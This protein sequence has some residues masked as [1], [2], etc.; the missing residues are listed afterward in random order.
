MTES[1]APF[2]AADGRIAHAVGAHLLLVD[3]QTRLMAAMPRGDAERV[4]RNV[5]RLIAAADAL[6]VPVTASLQY[7]QGLGPLRPAIA[8]ALER[9]ATTATTHVAGTTPTA[10]APSAARVV[11]DLHKTAFSCCAA[12][13]LAQRLGLAAPAA[14]VG[15]RNRGNDD[16]DAASRGPGARPAPPPAPD[17]ITEATG[18][19]VVCGV[20]AHI[21]VLQT[22]LALLASGQGRRRV[23]VVSDAVTSRDPEHRLDALAR[24]R[25][26]GVIVANHESILFEW[27]RD[28]A[29]PAFKRISALLR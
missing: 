20:E 22:A 1:R 24:L 25:A 29:H 6:G 15:E 10:E 23:F 12:P 7:P 16:T 26:E 17:A 13:A 14:S 18:D 27:L 9:A 28:A 5:V 21:C 4:E 8:E 2:A 11:G 3:L 19:V